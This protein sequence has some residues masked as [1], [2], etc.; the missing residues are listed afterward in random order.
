MA[1]EFLFNM[2]HNCQSNVN[3]QKRGLDSFFLLFENGFLCYYE[4]LFIVVDFNFLF[5]TL[6]FMVIGSPWNSSDSKNIFFYVKSKLF[7]ITST[8]RLK[9]D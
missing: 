3:L 5:P 4:I 9:V 7:F 8:Y 1:T 6:M 2:V